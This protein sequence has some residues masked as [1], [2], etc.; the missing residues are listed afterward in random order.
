[1]KRISVII[2]TYQHAQ[3][4]GLCLESLFAQTRKPDEVIVVDD[5]STDGTRKVVGTF[6]DK[7]HYFFQ[8]NQG[9]PSARNFGAREAV[10][11]YV[12]FCDADVV[13]APSMLEKME[14]AL[15]TH[16]EI[17]YVY[18]GMRFGSKR[19]RSRPF[20]AIELRKQNYIHTPSLIRADVLPRFDE[21][22]KRFQDWDLWLTLL[23]KG[24]IGMALEEELFTL[25]N[26]PGRKGISHWLPS[27][28]YRFPWSVLGWKPVHIRAYDEAREI[29]RLKH[30]L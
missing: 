25:V 6:G 20:D 10:G 15:N 8:E 1:M 5:G 29:I 22:L 2:A 9:A 7:V 23:A 3:T 26:V 16:P 17:A 4:V 27:F 12:L 18:S 21:S 13:A 11:D 30:R 28:F 19:F 14:N 24:K